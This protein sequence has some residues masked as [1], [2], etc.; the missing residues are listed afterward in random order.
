MHETSSDAK[1]T[2]TLRGFAAARG[3]GPIE[4]C[5]R[6][7]GWQGSLFWGQAYAIKVV[8]KI[9]KSKLRLISLKA[10]I[11]FRAIA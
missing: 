7:M 5:G 8:R 3:F 4:G 1:K 2:A 9:K 6:G 11:R 10:L